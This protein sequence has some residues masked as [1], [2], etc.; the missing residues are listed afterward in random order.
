MRVPGTY[1]KAGPGGNQLYQCEICG[2]F[3]RWWAS[4][5]IQTCSDSC[6]TVLKKRVAQSFKTN[7]ERSKK[8]SEKS[9]AAH[10][11]G[12]FKKAQ[13]ARKGINPRTL[14]NY[15]P[16]WKEDPV[17]R[18]EVKL[19]KALKHA[20]KL[21][22]TYGQV[23]RMRKTIIEAVEDQLADAHA[24]VLGEKEWSPTQA[25][26]FSTLLNKVV[27]D[28]QARHISKSEDNRPISELSQK[29]LEAIIARDE[30]ARRELA[31][32]EAIEEAETIEDPK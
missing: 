4:Q 29:E 32:R 31:K 13:E 19:A 30:K 3:F 10:K 15:R 2:S 20:E 9:K 12:A 17:K 11:R 16:P 18:K 25:R 24:V 28:L 8:I 21:D 14:P 26:V 22:L 5:N 6:R 27:P 23:H 7:R 1:E